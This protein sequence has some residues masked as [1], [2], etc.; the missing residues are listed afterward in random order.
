MKW[1]PLLLLAAC[2]GG[3]AAS[4]PR[5]GTEVVAL[6]NGQ[7]PAGA[8][9]WLRL[10]APLDDEAPAGELF[11]ARVAG[12]VRTTHGELLIPRGAVVVGRMIAGPWLLAESI[13][14]RGVTQPLAGWVIG[15][16]PPP[17]LGDEPPDRKTAD[18]GLDDDLPT[19]TR[20]ELRLVAPVA[21]VP[22]RDA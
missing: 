18:E 8:R 2:S 10:D 9:I 22:E 6:R 19:G 15:V 11:R 3:F 17:R 14:M 13:E 7:V 4:D 21:P 5:V 12:D 1:L 16:Q 20:L